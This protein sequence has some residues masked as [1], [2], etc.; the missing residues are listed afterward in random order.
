MFRVG[1]R[2]INDDWLQAKNHL[3][4]TIARL[5]GLQAASFSTQFTR[6]TTLIPFNPLDL[7]EIT[8]SLFVKIISRL[9]KIKIK[10][11]VTRLF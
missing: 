1:E 5:S 2:F 11:P 10:K 9:Q 8:K 4:S 7:L 3:L 6:E